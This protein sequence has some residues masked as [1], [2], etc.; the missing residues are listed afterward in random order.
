MKQLLYFFAGVGAGA[1]IGYT[2][3]K[4]KYENLADE[5]VASVK[6][7][8]ENKYKEEKF[9]KKVGE[10]AIMAEDIAKEN[11]YIQYNPTE[12]NIVDEDDVFEDDFPKEER[13]ENPYIIDVHD[14]E[15]FYHGFEKTCVTYYAGN[16]VLIN[17]EMEEI[18]V[19]SHI[20]LGNVNHLLEQE[21]VTAFIR[22]ER[23]GTDFEVLF[24]DGEYT[25]E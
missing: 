21:S 15:D 16:N 9:R 23:L 1:Y 4:K 2:I 6:E 22:N 19:D 14:F 25:D 17:D 12:I 13:A 18:D 3:A 10:V 8:Y 11:N 24:E 7:A 20:G 5:E